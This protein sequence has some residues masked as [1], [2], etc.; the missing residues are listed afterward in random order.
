MASILTHETLAPD[1]PLA[2][3]ELIRLKTW[4]GKR[5]DRPAV[6][7]EITDLA[8]HIASAI[9]VHRGNP[10]VRGIRDV[11]W[12]YEL[13]DPPRFSLYAV[14]EEEAD[15]GGAREWLA[16]VALEIP[17]DVGVAD[18]IEATDARRTSLYLIENSYSADV[19]DL[20][21]RGGT[22]KGAY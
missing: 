2:D 20:T 17:A 19:S 6:P 13:A 3:H 12:Q 11:L 16:T 9:T 22:P 15:P 5:Y 1:N 10:I 21:W 7:D 14:L 18:E 8:R 4:L